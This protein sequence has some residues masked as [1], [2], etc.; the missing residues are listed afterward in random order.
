MRA[1]HKLSAVTVTNL[2][3]PGLY[4]DGGCLYLRVAPGGSK[5]WIFRFGFAG[6]MRD[7]GLGPFPTVSLVNARKQAEAY[8]ELVAAGVDP[9]EARNSDRDAA[10]IAS[11]AAMTFEQCAKAYIK[12]HEAGWRNRDHRHQ[13][14]SS[15]K[16]Y[17][18]PIIGTLPVQA[19]DTA[20]VLKVLEPIWTEKPETASRVRGRIELVLSW[21]K[22]RGYRQGENPAIWR[23]HLDHLL[24]AKRKVHRVEHYAAL[25]YREIGTFMARLRADPSIS[26]RALELLILTVTRTSETLGAR[27]DEIDFE[28]RMWV[29]PANRMKAEREHRVPLSARAIA[30]LKEMTKVRRDEFVFPGK[31]QG[32]PA[33]SQHISRLARAPAVDGHDRSWP[34]L[35]LPRLGR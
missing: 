26:A 4:A 22:V 34:P 32:R 13:W 33:H 30:I 6:K 3:T 12:S 19:V 16:H 17:V 2:K 8:R 5:G 31:K 27:W 14:P 20:L 23:G 21:A 25:P 9:I 15:L 10:R 18:Y 11:L 35:K 24:P 1:I 28:Q 7:A 29:I